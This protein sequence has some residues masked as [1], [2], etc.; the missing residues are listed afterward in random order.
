LKIGTSGWQYD[1]WRHT[2]YPAGLAKSRWL[3][4]Y[5]EHFA[6]VESNS[7]FYRLPARETFVDWATRT[8]EDFEVAVKASRYLTHVLRLREPDQPVRRLMERLVGLGEKRGPVLLQLPPNLQAAPELL[9]AAL[10][11]FPVE[12]R[13]AVEPRHPSW[14]GD[15]TRAL[16][17]RRG[18]AWCLSDVDGRRPPLWRTAEWGYVRFHRGRA[19]PPPCY[20]RTALATWVEQLAERWPDGVVYCYFNN[21]ERGCAVRDARQL[22]L[23]ARRL[24]HET[25]RTPSAKDVTVRS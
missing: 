7:A 19:A 14:F 16:L 5:S 20:G 23:V 22:G 11:A 13:V 2:F 12:I 3:E 18:A 24:G 10:R 8:P 9:D 17:E 6:T 4:H 15:D 25:T 21:D 1:D